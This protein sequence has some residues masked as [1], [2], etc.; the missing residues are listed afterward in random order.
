MI[1]QFKTSNA[2]NFKNE[3]IKLVEAGKL[4]TWDISTINGVKY[5]KHLGQWG[6]KG[7][8]KLTSNNNNDYLSLEIFK[9]SSYKGEITDFEGYYLGRFCELIFVNFPEKFTSIEK[10]II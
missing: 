10:K 4:S 9:F 1:L 3:I 8:A 5:L 2:I 6:E 7:V